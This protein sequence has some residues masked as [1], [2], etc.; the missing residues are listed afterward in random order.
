[1]IITIENMS[2]TSDM[3]LSAI[4]SCMT[5][6][7][8]LKICD[9]LELYVSPNLKKDETAR[10]LAQEILHSPDDVL[11]VLNKQELQIVDEFV[12]AGPNKYVVRKSRKTYYKLQQFGLVVTYIDKDSVEW[13]MLM[14]DSV[15]NVLA[16]SYKVYLEMAEK[17]IKLP[18][19]KMLRLMSFSDYLNGL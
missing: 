18:S 6:V 9:K 11:H 2:F 16:S 5:K 10:R 3:S 13:R 8:M 12:Q 4:L 17:G 7:E 19:K 14:P 15:R 1:M